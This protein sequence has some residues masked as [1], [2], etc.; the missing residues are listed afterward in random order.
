MKGFNSLTEEEK[1]NHKY[2]INIQSDVP[3]F[4]NFFNY[5]KLVAGSSILAANILS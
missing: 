4:P 1:I 3:A 5:S 2:N